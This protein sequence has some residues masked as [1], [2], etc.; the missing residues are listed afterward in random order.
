VSG[1]PL[2]FGLK[3]I[4]EATSVEELRTVWR[5]ADEAGFDHCWA[6]DHLLPVKGDRTGPVLDGWS[7]LGAMSQVTTRVRMGLLVTGNSYRHPGMLA[8]MATTIDHLS[9]GRLEFGIGSGWAEYEH[10]M[11]GLEYGTPGQRLDRLGEALQIIRSLWTEDVTDFDGRHYKV[12]RAIAFPKPVQRPHP[13]LWIGGRGERKTLR[14]V[15]QYAN[16]WNVSARE[17]GE[18]VRLSGVLDGHCERAGRDPADVRRTVQLYY[19]G[20]PDAFL[21]TVEPYL[22]AGFSEVVLTLAAR[23]AGRDPIPDAQSAASELLPRLRQL[24]D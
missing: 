17:V 20:D 10:R 5:I 23:S 2:R 3:L 13:P 1:A 12:T 11:L 4:P 18:D 9:G 8:K 16:V 15:A 22:A 14:L 19:A 24:G 6:Y 21:T 7:L